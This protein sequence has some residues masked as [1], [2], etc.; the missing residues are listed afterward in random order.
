[1]LT[2]VALRNLRKSWKENEDF[3]PPFQTAELHKSFQ[4]SKLTDKSDEDLRRKCPG[5]SS[6]EKRKEQIIVT[7][8]FEFN[9]VISEDGKT[10]NECIFYKGVN[11]KVM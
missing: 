10:K 1:L 6:K 4:G 11:M 3:A 7:S 8:R 2:K 5:H 9:F